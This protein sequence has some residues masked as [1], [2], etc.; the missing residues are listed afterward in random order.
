MEEEEEE[1][2]GSRGGGRISFCIPIAFPLYTRCAPIGGGTRE[3]AQFLVHYHCTPNAFILYSDWRRRKRAGRQME[4]RGRR[5][6]GEGTGAEE[7]EKRD[8]GSQGEEKEEDAERETEEG[9]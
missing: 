5:K 8:K 3:T 6:V 7:G 2:D 1:E 4:V 9:L